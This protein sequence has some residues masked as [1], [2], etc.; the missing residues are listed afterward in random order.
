MTPRAPRVC[1]KLYAASDAVPDAAFVPIFHRWIRDRALDF[2]FIDV[3]DYA[4]VPEGP[5]VML[6]TDGVT[7]GLDRADGQLGLLAQQRRSVEG[8]TAD[9]IALALQQTLAVANALEREGSLRGRLVFGRSRI[10][11]EINDRL[12]APNDD[13]SFSMFAPAVIEATGRVFQGS[14]PTVTRARGDTRDRLAIDAFVGE[15]LESA[16][17][18][19]L[20]AKVP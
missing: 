7:F 4:H 1:V 20:S 9:T 14:R 10:R 19:E 5:A 6:V 13:A 15:L 12:L 11:V 18:Q 3:A 17:L 16:T 2:V 8:T